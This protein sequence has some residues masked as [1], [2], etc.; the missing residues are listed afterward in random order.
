MVQSYFQSIQ[1]I[2]SHITKY[3]EQY[4]YLQ[5][6][7]SIQLKLFNKTLLLYQ[8][9]NI[10][11]ARVILNYKCKNSIICYQCIQSKLYAYI[12]LYFQNLQ[13]IRLQLLLQLYVKFKLQRGR[14]INIVNLLLIYNYYY[15]PKPQNLTKKINQLRINTY[16][17]D[18]IQSGRACNELSNLDRLCQQNIWFHSIQFYLNLKYYTTLKQV[19]IIIINNNLIQRTK[20]H[21]LCYQF[22]QI[23]M[24]ND[25]D[26]VLNITCKITQTKEKKNSPPKKVRYA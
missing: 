12:L 16:S 26:Y 3:I 2:D 1:S 9:K 19:P 20:L 18:Y 4:T 8:N 14:K 6:Q 13:C 22:N 15:L 24:Q 10:I 7:I 23:D 21:D 25:V 17:S 5:I 11:L